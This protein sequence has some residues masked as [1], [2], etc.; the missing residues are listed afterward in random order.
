MPGVARVV[1]V[2]FIRCNIEFAVL[3][4]NVRWGNIFIYLFIALCTGHRSCLVCVG[5]IVVHAQALHLCVQFERQ[6]RAACSECN[7][8]FAKRVHL[9]HCGARVSSAKDPGDEQVP[10]QN[11]E[12]NGE[13]DFAS[14]CRI[15]RNLPIY[16]SLHYINLRETLLSLTQ[17]RIRRWI[18]SRLWNMIFNKEPLASV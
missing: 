3:S 14:F 2:G 4:C 17:F 11:T 1:S 7:S 12:W 16:H 5:S 10:L 8:C 15:I 18:P 9:I 13:T 6:V